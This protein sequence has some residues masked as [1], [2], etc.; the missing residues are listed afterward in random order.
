MMA[1]PLEKSSCSRSARTTLPALLA[2]SLLAAAC[3]GESEAANETAPSTGPV[4]VVEFP[5][6]RIQNG[7]VR[8]SPAQAGELASSIEVPGQ[9]EPDA[10]QTQK[11][12]APAR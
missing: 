4:T 10:D 5:A 2:L 9:L 1:I 3:G 8:W 7:G 6:A 11:L 12:G